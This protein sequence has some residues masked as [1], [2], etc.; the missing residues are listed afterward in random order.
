MKPKSPACVSCKRPTTEFYSFDLDLPSLPF[1]GSGCYYLWLSRA[2]IRQDG[3]E[4]RG[5]LRTPRNNDSQGSGKLTGS[6]QATNG[7][8]GVL[9]QQDD[10][11]D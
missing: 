9:P 4:P 5:R 2:L 6:A 3:L 10:D 8:T 1:C 11:S 7:N